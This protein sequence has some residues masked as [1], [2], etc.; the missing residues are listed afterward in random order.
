MS[1]SLNSD[2]AAAAALAASLAAL[3]AAKSV[4]ELTSPVSGTIEEICVREGDTVPIGTPLAKVR[5]TAAG[6]R[7]RP[8][9]PDAGRS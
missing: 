4:F 7:Q 2:A 3:E 1:L 5:T 8:L 9:T 6:Q